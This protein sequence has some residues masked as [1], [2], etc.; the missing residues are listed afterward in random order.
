[1]KSLLLQVV[2]E[3]APNS[4][5]DF[6]YRQLH[7]WRNMNKPEIGAVLS[8]HMKDVIGK[9]HAHKHAGKQGPLVAT[10]YAVI[11]DVD[12]TPDVVPNVS[13]DDVVEFEKHAIAF[14]TRLVDAGDKH[15]KSKG[16][17]KGKGKG[18]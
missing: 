8:D 4:G 11:D 6:Y 5:S 16:G 14:A 7:E 13:L 2:V 18:K 15:A 17:D 9:L 1:M 10:F 3:G 12:Q